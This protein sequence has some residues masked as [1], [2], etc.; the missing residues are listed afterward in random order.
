MKVTEADYQKTLDVFLQDLNQI[1][2]RVLSVVL[3][4][5]MAKSTVRPGKS[6]VLDAILFLDSQLTENKGRFLYLLEVMTTACEHIAESGLPFKHPFAWYFSDELQQ[7]PVP[8]TAEMADDIATKVV[9][10][11]DVRDRVQASDAGR[12][13]FCKLFFLSY[14][15]LQSEL[16]VFQAR[17]SLSDDDLSILHYLLRFFGKGLPQ[18]ICAAFGKIVP[19]LHAVRT[20]KELAP[21]VNASVF[22]MMLSETLFDAPGAQQKVRTVIAELLELLE[23][24]HKKLSQRE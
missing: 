14:R 24:I 19:T 12:T 15:Y 4:G 18:S 13:V 7:L 16:C 22:E 10:G 8:D 9:F 23:V 11:E 20:I 21:E 17:N 1:D 6:D 3:Y 5:S 2:D